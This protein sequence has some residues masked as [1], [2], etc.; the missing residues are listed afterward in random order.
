MP[1]SDASDIYDD[2]YELLRTLEMAAP[3][4]A[5]IPLFLVSFFVW[6]ALRV[7]RRAFPEA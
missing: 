4:E 6:L 7:K 5:R 2:A 3:E 1:H